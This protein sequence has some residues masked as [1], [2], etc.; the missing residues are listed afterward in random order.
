MGRNV[1]VRQ[2]TAGSR[3]YLNG[4]DVEVGKK[5]LTTI[6]PFQPMGGHN[7][8]NPNDTAQVYF[9]RGVELQCW[10]IEARGP[11]KV[12]M[13]YAGQHTAVSGV[14]DGRRMRF[15]TPQGAAV[16]RSLK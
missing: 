1:H 3:R 5:A 14:G 8:R 4:D 9:V 7:K 15:Y 11:F 6:L 12:E 10:E 16:R 2:V 13:F